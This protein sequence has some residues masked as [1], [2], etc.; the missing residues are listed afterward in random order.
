MA[1]RSI[2]DRPDICLQSDR[3]HWRLNATRRH[4]QRRLAAGHR[5]HRTARL[6]QLHDRY[7]R[8]RDDGLRECRQPLA[9]VAVHQA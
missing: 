2:A 4:R 3:R 9:S 1:F 7:V 5:V 6:Y 8:H